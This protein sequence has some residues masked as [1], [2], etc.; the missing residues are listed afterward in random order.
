MNPRTPD[1]ALRAE[2]LERLDRDQRAREAFFDGGGRDW[3][4]VAEVDRDNRAF[5][6]PVIDRHGWLGSDLVGED[7]A[8]ACWL[9]VQHAEPE[10][11][12]AWLPLMQDA[13]NA[14]HADR[15]DLAYLEDRVN[16][17]HNRPQVYGTQGFAT[18]GD[19]EARL[20]PTIDPAGL[21]E[22][23]RAV[24]LSPLDDMTVANAWT[25]EEIA[26][27]KSGSA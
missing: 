16:L 11:R 22:R 13:V 2:L 7:G 10:Q 25:I 19:G 27:W 24:G 14:R 3:S 5:L 21:N 8:H 9:L 18:S 12:A 1:P 20:W 23:R 17:D 26:A 15:R 6:A 4:P